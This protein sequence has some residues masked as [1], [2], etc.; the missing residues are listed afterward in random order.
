MGFWI[1]FRMGAG[2]QKDQAILGTLSLTPGDG[3]GIGEWV[4]ND[5][6]YVMKSPKNP[7]TTGFRELPG[8]WTRRYWEVECPERVW[9]P[10]TPSPYHAVYIFSTWL[11]STWLSYNPC[12]KIIESMKGVMG[13][14][15]F[16][17]LVRS[18]KGPI[19]ELASEGGGQSC[20]TEPLTCAVCTNSGY[21]VW[22]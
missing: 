11:F 2:D 19:S 5:H 1:A 13:A 17:Q 9:K 18:I 12:I 21:L 3:R 10:H 20:G 15:D 4:N 22:E 7:Y 6:A 14:S 16:S 8:W